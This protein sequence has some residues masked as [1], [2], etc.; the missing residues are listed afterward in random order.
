MNTIHPWSE[1]Q[2]GSARLGRW[3]TLDS[4]EENRHNRE[5]NNVWMLGMVMIS[6]KARMRRRRVVYFD[7]KMDFRGHMDV[8]YDQNP[9]IIRLLCH[10]HRGAWI[11]QILGRMGLHRRWKQKDACILALFRELGD[12]HIGRQW[13]VSAGQCVL[14]C[15][16][17]SLTTMHRGSAHHRSLLWVEYQADDFQAGGGISLK[18]SALFAAL[19]RVRSSVSKM[20]KKRACR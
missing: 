4:E 19:S 3:Y 11:Y 15:R 9:S 17:S 2:A 20:I 1:V 7:N 5:F 16:F 14:H 12:D 6:G 13:L 10:S 8:T 18:S